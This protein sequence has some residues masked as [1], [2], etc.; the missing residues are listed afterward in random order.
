MTINEYCLHLSAAPE[1]FRKSRILIVPNRQSREQIRCYYLQSSRAKLVRVSEAITVNAFVQMPNVVFGALKGLI[2]IVNHSDKIAYVIGLDSYL[3]L[4]DSNAVSEAFAELKLL[5]SNQGLHA[6]YLL[7]A[8]DMGEIGSPF[9][10]PRYHEEKAI[11]RVG[12]QEPEILFSPENVSF[13]RHDFILP[14]QVARKSIRSFLSDMEDETSDDCA[15]SIIIDI[16]GLQDSVAGVNKAIHQLFTLRSYME[17]VWGADCNFTEETMKWLHK[18]ICE[19]KYSNA[20]LLTTIRNHFD[21]TGNQDL[22]ASAPKKLYKL[23]EVEQEAFVWMLKNTLPN[24]CYL[25]AVLTHKDF[26]LKNVL[27]CYVCAAIDF[28]DYSKAELLADERKKAL[29]EI[30][31][32]NISSEIALFIDQVKDKSTTLV[33]PWLN[34]GTNVEKNELVRRLFCEHGPTGTSSIL[35]AYPSLDAYLSEYQFD[36][37]SLNKYFTEYRSQKLKNC[38]TEEFYNNASCIEVPVEVQS[39]DSIIQEHS[40]D[41][42]AALLVVDA[43][44]AEY[45]PL[46]LAIAFSRNLGI[47]SATLG[48][49]NLPTSTRF[50][51]ITWPPERKLPDIKQIDTIIHHGAETHVLKPP[52]ENFV[53][54]LDALEIKVFPAVENALR[55]YTKVVLTSDHGSSRL[56]VCAYQQGLTKTIALPKGLEI[57]DWRFTSVSHDSEPPDGTKRSFCGGYW[58]V[59]GYNR[60]SKQGG[61]YFELHGGMT[62]E[63]RLVPIIV[64]KRGASFKQKQTPE[65]V[66]A[67]SQ[68]T[69]NG[70]FDL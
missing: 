32:E 16:D 36:L 13:V 21:P 40:S 48:Y 26:S 3:A 62:L 69:E 51:Q 11:I 41:T 59:K 65:I 61:K 24:D 17:S 7:G 70:D 38:V 66:S 43:L 4:L 33:A 55:K 29:R 35:K 67:S 31:V 12:E 58:V 37:D 23:S 50:N 54:L 14:N 10:H 19:N 9:S 20:S 2:Q 15:T 1:R 57:D 39:R 8:I 63:E 47:E 27:S 45:F 18:L 68:I 22:C 49:S 64:F 42:A 5:L 6:V 52:E 60:F 28:L 34:N 30:G 44:G 46:L 53:A 25:F 56:A